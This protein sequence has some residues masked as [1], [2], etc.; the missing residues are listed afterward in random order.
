MQ[1][2][3]LTRAKATLSEIVARLLY[4]KE[5][6]VITRKR[7]PVAAIV[8]YHEWARKESAAA[9]GL[10]A[11][12]GALADL[13]REI[14]EMVDAAYAARAEAKDRPVHL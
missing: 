4:R 9:E 6:V 11:A 10:A 3:P 2:I 13:D 8:P 7:V 12:A 1:I 5:A 14:D